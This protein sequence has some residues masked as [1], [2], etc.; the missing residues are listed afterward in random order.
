MRDLTIM[1]ITGPIKTLIQNP[2]LEKEVLG[3]GRTLK[4]FLFI[5]GFVL[6][7]CIPL[8]IVAAEHRSYGSNTGYELF[9]VI[10]WVQSACIALAIPAYASTAI[11]GERQHRTYDLLR[12]TILKPWEI[13]WGKFLAILSY[14]VIF[15]LAFLPLVA[16][17]FL[18]GGTDPK[19]V[20]TCYAYLLLGAATA[21]MFCLMV[22]AGSMNPIKSILVGY[23]FM[24]VYAWVWGLFAVGFLSQWTGRGFRGG[25]G[26]LSL[27][28][29]ETISAY[30]SYAFL[31][32]LF[33]IAATA[34]MKPPSWNK[35]TALRVWYVVFTLVSMVFFFIIVGTNIDTEEMAAYMLPFVGIPGIFAAVGFCSEP[36][37]VHPRLQEK[38]K[39]ASP[40]FQPFLPG[41]IGSRFFVHV[42]VV[43]ALAL[44]MAVASIIS[45]ANFF[46]DTFWLAVG[47][48]IYLAF[49]CS[50]SRTVRTFWDSAR[51]RIIALLILASL[52]LLP[53]LSLLFDEHY[54]HAPAIAWIDPFVA[55]AEF[56][57]SPGRTSEILGRQVFLW[58]HVIGIVVMV[59]VR[60]ARLTKIGS[61]A[62]ANE[63]PSQT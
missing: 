54:S 40:L 20:A 3:T 15:L 1:R 63:A 8:L 42:V 41:G 23:A 55:F 52:M 56:I 22:S 10:F 39:Q 27:L 57:D 25:A 33:Y 51:S 60:R 61:P 2:I 4:F 36:Q 50:V 30:T 12:I 37:T 38:A 31:L 62:Q 6:L 47:I 32:S 19:L 26:Q 18:Y 45:T 48:F 11:A 46:E 53:L 5:V 28:G 7:A 24:I 43:I 29:I 58:F 34:L 21:I 44:S 49:C 35:T 17:C 14:I 59:A 16:I 9:E 13:V